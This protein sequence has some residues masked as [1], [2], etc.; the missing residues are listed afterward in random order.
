MRTRLGHRQDV[1]TTCDL[2]RVRILSVQGL[3]CIEN[4]I[5]ISW[6]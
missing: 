1:R 6:M 3:P 5:L 4:P 2:F